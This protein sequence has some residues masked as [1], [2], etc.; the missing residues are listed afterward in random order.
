MNLKIKPTKTKFEKESWGNQNETERNERKEHHDED[1]R[2]ERNERKESW[3]KQNERVQREGIVW[4]P[5]HQ[6]RHI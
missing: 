5:E 6:R 4:D 1:E 2:N 3:G